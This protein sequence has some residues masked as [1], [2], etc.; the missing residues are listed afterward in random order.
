[1]LVIRSITLLHVI[2]YRVSHIRIK[3]TK[4]YKELGPAILVLPYNRVLLYPTSFNNVPPYLES[5]LHTLVVMLG[6]SLVSFLVVKNLSWKVCIKFEYI[7]LMHMTSRHQKTEV[8][9]CL[10][11]NRITRKSR[12]QKCASRTSAYKAMALTPKMAA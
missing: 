1:M 9:R 8:R 5:G 4:K 7:D 10:G 3:K 6:E 11:V 12:C 2:V